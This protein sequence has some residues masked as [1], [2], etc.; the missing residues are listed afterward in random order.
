MDIARERRKH[1]RYEIELQAIISKN[2][3][4]YLQNVKLI[5]ISGGGIS[6]TCDNQIAIGETIMIYFPFITVQG[7]VIWQ[8]GNRYGAMFQN[9]LGDE[10]QI[11]LTKHCE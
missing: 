4:R 8:Q 3:H 1:K 10:L 11:F 9:P 7:Y 6:F 5:N 2:D